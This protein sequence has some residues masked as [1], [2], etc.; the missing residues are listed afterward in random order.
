MK[1]S[2]MN[3]HQQMVAK[4]VYE[5]FNSFIGGLENTLL[6]YPE[7]DEEYQSAKDTL[8]NHQVLVD[9]IYQEV[10]YRCGHGSYATAAR[11]AGKAFIV[12]RIECRLAKEG[13]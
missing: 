10:M 2:E 12:E 9:T 11:F 3:G 4:I 8:A 13:Y 7:S 1:L 5:E 6:D